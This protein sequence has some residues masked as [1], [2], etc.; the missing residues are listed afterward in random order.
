[1][2]NSNVIADI[3]IDLHFRSVRYN[4]NNSS[5]CYSFFVVLAIIFIE[6][7]LLQPAVCGINH[8]EF[9]VQLKV[10][11]CRRDCLDKVSVHFNKLLKFIYKRYK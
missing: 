8:N 5:R 11:Q 2:I 3:G 4:I 1:M 9:L 6:C 10:P 7:S